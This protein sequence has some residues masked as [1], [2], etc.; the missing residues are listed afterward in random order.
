MRTPS[1]TPLAAAQT[2][3]AGEPPPRFLSPE[4][5]LPKVPVRTRATDCATALRDAALA[6]PFDIETYCRSA[7]RSALTLAF[8][9]DTA[10]SERSC[11]RQIQVVFALVRGGELPARELSRVFQPW[12]NIGRLRVIQGRWEEAL[13]HFTDPDDLRSADRG[14]PLGGEVLT[15]EETRAVLAYRA[16][17]NFVRDSH[18]L[19]TAKAF[20]RGGRMDLLEEHA[21]RWRAQE[22]RIPHVR[23]AAAL[24]A[25]RE[26]GPVALGSPQGTA[27][28]LEDVA[29]RI[30]VAAVRA[31]HTDAL[32]VELAALDAVTASADAVTVLRAGAE[33]L[34]S[35]GREEEAVRALR[36]AERACREIDD[37]VDLYGVLRAL[38]P[39]SPEAGHA[40][41]AHSIAER[42]GHALIRRAAGLPAPPAV[43][44]EPS[45][46]ALLDAEREAVSRTCPSPLEFT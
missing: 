28:A 44:D 33:T 21:Q 12:V 32:A 35:R 22:K 34:L 27:P 41:E 9:G 7:N 38:A 16:A 24:V 6:R 10:E 37:E 46:A 30:H 4:N 19:E 3:P 23:E 29:I 31:S 2:P 25:L 20:A 26:D 40:E 18:V 17:A 45:L 5:R 42:S 36:T 13:G 43:S 39:L 8:A 1:G 15:P 14:L 11:R